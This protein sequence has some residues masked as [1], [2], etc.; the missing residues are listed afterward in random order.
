MSLSEGGSGKYTVTLASQPTEEVTIEVTGVP[1]PVVLTSKSRLTFNQDNWNIPQEVTVTAGVDNDSVDAWGVVGHYPSDY[2]E[3]RSWTFLRVYVDDDDPPL[4]VSGSSS[5]EYVENG[6]MAAD[7]YAVTNAGSATVSWALFGRDRDDF[8]ISDAGVL[9]FVATPDYEQPSDADRDNVYMVTIHASSGSSTG[10]L[11]VAIVV[12][13]QAEGLTASRLTV[14]V[15]EGDSATYTVRLDS[16]PTDDVDVSV[17]VSS[18]SG[19]TVSPSSLKFTP[20]NSTIAQTITVS[21]DEDEDAEDG[22]ATVTHAPSGGGYDTVPDLRVGVTVADDDTAAVNL[23]HTVL[24]VDEGDSATYTVWLDTKPTGQVKVTPSVASDSGL[25]VSPSSLTFTRAN[26]A[27]ARTVTVSAQEDED[28]EDGTATVE[29]QASGGDY[30]E[31]SVDPVVVRVDD[32][33][34]KSVTLSRTVLEVDE[35]ESVTYTVKLDTRPTRSVTISLTVPAG[36]GVSVRPSSLTF[37]P[38]NYA[39]AQTVTVSAAND[40][41]STNETVTVTHAPSG[42]GYGGVSV[43][44]V[45]VTVR[46]DDIAA[47]SLSTDS[48][49]VVEDQGAQYTVALE[50]EPTASVTVA[51]T[52]PSDSGVSVRPSSLTFT[53]ANYANA[54]TV[55]VSAADDADSTNEMATVTHRGSGGGYD[56][57]IA[58]LEVTVTDNDT[59]GVPLSTTRLTVPEGGSGEYMVRLT[60][61]PTGPVTVTPS[62]PPN[63]GVSVSPASLTFTLGN[64][65]AVQTVTVSA[66]HDADAHDGAATVTHTAAGGGYGAVAVGSVAVTVDDDDRVGVTLDTASLAVPEGGSAT[67][68]V[69]L[70]TKPSGSVTVTPSV[71][72]DSGL[73]LNPSALTFTGDDYAVPQMV[74]VSAAKD[75]DAQDA[76]AT[77]LHTAA[78]GGYDGVAID[79]VVVRV[80]DNDRAGVTIS[81]T[82]LSVNEGASATYTVKLNAA[83]SAVVT[84]TPVLP[85]GSG[86]SVSPQTL[87]FST[88][89]YATVQ[90]MTVRAAHDDDGRDGQATLVH[91]ARGGG[92]DGVWISPL[93]VTIADDDPRT[94]PALSSTNV[95]GDRLTLTYDQ[96]LDVSSVPAPE[97]FEISV[98]SPDAMSASGAGSTGL[99]A[100]SPSAERIDVNEVQIAGATVV[101]TLARQV[102]VGERLT[103]SYTPGENP[104]RSESGIEAP[105]ISALSVAARPSG[106]RT[107]HVALFSSTASAMRHSFVRVINHSD[108]D[109]EVQVTA[110]D[111]A[112]IRSDAVTLRVAAG[113]V[114]HFNSRDLEQGN[115][116]REIMPPGVGRSTLGDWRLEFT[117]ERDIEVLAYVR[118]HEGA[119]ASVHDV[120][121]EDG[122]GKHRVVF[123]NPAS[124]EG[125]MSWLRLVNPGEE[126]ARVDITGL[127]DAG[128]AG[129]SA[130]VLTLG[131]GT[132]R[133]LSARALESGRGEG[134]SGALGDGTGKWRLWVRAD[135]PILVMSLVRSSEGPHLTNMSTVPAPAETVHRVPYLP[136]ATNAALDGMVRI[137]NHSAEAGEVSIM[138]FDTAGGRYGPLTLAMGANQAVQFT[139]VHLEEGTADRGLVGATGQGEGAW[140]LELTSALDIEALSY[141]R[142]DDGL[143]ASM[144]DVAPV[145]D[146]GE[147]RIGFFN[148]ASNRYR[149]SRL[150]IINPSE[151]EAAVRVTGLDDAGESGDSAVEFTL[152]AR[153]SRSLSAQMLESGEAEGLSGALGDGHGKWRL[154]VTADRPVRVMSLLDSTDRTHRTNVSTAPSEIP[155]HRAALQP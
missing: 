58:T 4:L 8:S 33:D 38:A 85:T 31:V 140:R 96:N 23:S 83:P 2:G 9:S 100:G 153:G 53:P 110:I 72:A 59:A 26:Y 105:A 98:D 147:H 47:I 12:R 131:A 57:I 21:A 79:P 123:F 116:D 46:D 69:K 14:T 151:S 87:T 111:E 128:E 143:L 10:F 112:G 35:E 36:T 107:V 114:V 30:S 27:T 56:A 95:D 61:E 119:L 40:A 50:S 6:T 120:V 80:T 90:V 82:T 84:V 37:T 62:V 76:S 135:R 45:R 97:D 41:D 124:N 49:G 154:Q 71:P 137:I 126:A 20:A 86:L 44:T 129:E 149:V 18:D 74:T 89:N 81:R 66:S 43:D 54:Q 22:T 125:R 130:I 5:I 136:S 106:P 67:Y 145:D 48:L 42:G 132:S 101:L 113:T 150:R 155:T 139:S 3:N 104:V 91:V 28:A 146:S 93:R 39:N 109:G 65:A 52:L 75:A 1:L 25:L 78:G 142:T 55:T 77:L 148:P 7:T 64:Y 117:S 24:D 108:T 122:P 17:S 29:H 141:V 144:H 127:D 121:P 88:H 103:V 51:V 102:P 68:T 73:K 32:D 118:N 152:A 99:L 16:E 133:S 92:Y 13:D 115:A 63:S 70:D 94:A 19:V 138:A 15:D 60:T 34:T 11:P 134:L